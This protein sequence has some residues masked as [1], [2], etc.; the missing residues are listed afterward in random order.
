MN[1][2][3]YYLYACIFLT[4]CG[5]SACSDE[6][7]PA[8]EEGMLSTEEQTAINVPADTASNG[9]FTLYSLSQNKVIN[10]SDSAS[11]NWD[12]AFAG[13]TILVNGGTSGPGA[14]EAQ[15]VD[16][17]FDDI[18]V[19]PAAGYQVDA[20][21]TPAISGWYR[22]TGD[23]SPAHAILPVP[24]KVIV[25]KT[26]T[27]DYARMEIVSYY[28]GNPDTSTAE[29]ADLAT[30]PASRYYTFVYSGLEMSE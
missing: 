26:A 16:G 25:L 21:G 17:I 11:T 19:A 12:I 7:E 15:V 27:G 10:N 20:E 2:K 8:P 29:F 22:Y 9:S 1:T 18:R 28:Q 5:I 30:R 23:A 14:G 6:N 4:L 13:T 24:G 3:M